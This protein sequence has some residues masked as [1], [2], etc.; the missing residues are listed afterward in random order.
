MTAKTN[1]MNDERERI[2]G[3]LDHAQAERRRIKQVLLANDLLFRTDDSP[4]YAGD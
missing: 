2:K 4:Q 3:Q 1:K